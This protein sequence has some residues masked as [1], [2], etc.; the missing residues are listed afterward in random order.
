MT[1]VLLAASALLALA[2]SPAFA[3]TA[4]T[5]T[6]NIEGSVASKCTVLNGTSA[7]EFR[8]TISLG[9]LAASDGTLNSGLSGSNAANPAGGSQTFRVNCTQANAAVSVTAA[10]LKNTATAPTGYSNTIDYQGRVEFA[11]VGGGSSPAVFTD[12]SAVAAATTGSLGGGVFLAN[13]A[14][15]VV[16]K[17]HT[18][19]AGSGSPLLVAGDYVGSIS[20][21][22]TPGA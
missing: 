12:N 10:A 7:S 19:T 8:S 2:A 5:G 11:T 22:I 21:V 16:I 18:L 15:N 6:V 14:G 13:Q 17:A 3:Q 9:E 4:V 1:R 20:V